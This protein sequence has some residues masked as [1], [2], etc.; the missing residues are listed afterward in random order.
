MALDECLELVHQY[1]PPGGVVMDLFA[2]S[3]KVAMAA[4]RLN[5]TSISVE[6]NRETVDL[7]T[8][9]L[10][11][12]YRWNKLQGRLVSGSFLLIRVGK[13]TI[14]LCHPSPR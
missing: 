1:C 2:G 9:R 7:A 14:L 8:T 10:R 12:Y 13:D 11:R 5:R 6:M 3:C 4:M